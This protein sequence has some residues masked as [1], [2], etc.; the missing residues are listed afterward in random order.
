MLVT[1]NEKE[2]KGELG[3]AWAEEEMGS[4]QDRKLYIDPF[5]Q[6]SIGRKSL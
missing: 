3:G 5:N 2:R 1:R 4:K 6:H